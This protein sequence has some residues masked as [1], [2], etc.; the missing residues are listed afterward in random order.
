VLTVLGKP[1]ELERL[2]DVL[3]GECLPQV[4]M[5]LADIFLMS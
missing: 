1:L 3:H 4:C 2:H 5:L